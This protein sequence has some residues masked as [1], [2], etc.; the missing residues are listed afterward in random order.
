M[1]RDRW[2]AVIDSFEFE[3]SNQIVQQQVK[4]AEVNIEVQVV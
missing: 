2:L 1:L 4:L 3:K